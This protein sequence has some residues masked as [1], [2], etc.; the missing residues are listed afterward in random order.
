[1]NDLKT[2]LRSKKA[3]LIGWLV[4]FA[5]LALL[6]FGAFDGTFAVGA[7]PEAVNQSDGTISSPTPFQPEAG[8]SGFPFAGEQPH[9][10]NNTPTPMAT[11]TVEGGVY[12]TP[13]PQVLPTLPAISPY[14]LPLGINPLT[15]MP[16]ASSGLLERRP[17]AI[18]VTLFPRYV[19]PQSGLTLADVVFEYYIE[20]GLTRFIAVFYGNNSDIVGPVRSGRYFDEHVARMYHSY[21]VFK[22]AD[23]RVYDHLKA[24]DINQFLV[25]PGNTACPPFIVGK[26]ERETYNNIFF[27]VVKFQ[28]CLAIK[29]KDNLRQDLRSSYFSGAP[30]AFSEPA[31]RVFTRYSA[32][33]YHYWGYDR[34]LHKYFRHQEVKDTRD[35]KP[36]SYAPLLDTVTGQQVTADNVVVIFVPHTFD[37][38]FH[39]EDEVYHIDLIQSGKAYLFRDGVVIP[40]FWRRL[41]I[42]QPLLITDV[43]GVP[44]PLKLGRTFYEVIGTNSTF[45]RDGNDWHFRFETP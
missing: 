8:G 31:E 6:I 44:L 20:S 29:G 25:V 10:V 27:N 21:L 11:I 4:F 18:K 41:E 35:G 43:N 7:Q 39:E 42:D 45:W 1:V 32:D 17:I 13:I 2:F 34:L 24:T 19:R 14:S 22:Y 33:D 36:E 28:N 23:K 9:L 15:G 5:L 3:S 37:N 16:P 12:P 26:Q 38:Q 40:A 30:P